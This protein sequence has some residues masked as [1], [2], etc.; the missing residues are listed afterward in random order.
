MIRFPQRFH[1][2]TTPG[3]SQLGAAALT[4]EQEWNSA[5]PREQQAHL[6]ARKPTEPQYTPEALAAATAAWPATP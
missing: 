6:A 4:V 1:S 2:S 3:A 5:T